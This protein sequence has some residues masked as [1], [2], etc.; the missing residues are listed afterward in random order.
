M[1]AQPGRNY[2]NTRGI[3]VSIAPL[4]VSFLLAGCGGGTH[5]GMDF[6]S[7]RSPFW[8]QAMREVQYNPAYAPNREARQV[9]GAYAHRKVMRGSPVEKVMALTFDDGPHPKWTPQ[10]LAILKNYDVKATFFVV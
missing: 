8:L 10:L 6:S 1:R 7:E 2:L 3:E 4:L 5:A 9:L